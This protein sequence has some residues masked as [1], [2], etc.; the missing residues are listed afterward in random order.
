MLMIS[1][2]MP[3][4]PRVTL[5]PVAD[6]SDGAAQAVGEE[7][8]DAA[9]Y[10]ERLADP[11]LINAGLIVR[12]GACAQLLVPLGGSRLG[13]FLPVPD[14]VTGLAVR[15][16]LAGR[17]G[18]PGVRLRWSAYADCCHHVEW[19]ARAPVCDDDEVRGRFYGYSAE[20]IRR[21]SALDERL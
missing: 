19:G 13:G 1:P 3:G 18:F 2:G 16:L 20:A 7:E 9:Y 11:S 17:P 10:R 8:T 21:F 14:I 15:G 5:E 12:I 4:E 6:A